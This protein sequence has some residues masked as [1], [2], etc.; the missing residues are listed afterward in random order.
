MFKNYLTYQFAVSFDQAC[1]VMELPIPL[2][3]ELQRCS[4]AMLNQFTRSLQTQDPLERSKCLFVCL[5]YLRDCGEILSGVEPVP[6]DLSSKYDI[7]NL[8]FEHLCEEA[9][10]CE[11]GQ[12]R[13]L[14]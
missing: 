6:A 5:T 11:G 13:M 9:S 3:S 12:F 4:T 14:G 10:K 2:K 8:R 7:L 1:A